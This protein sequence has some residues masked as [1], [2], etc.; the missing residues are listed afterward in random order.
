MKENEGLSLI[1]AALTLRSAG[2]PIT[3][4]SLDA[5][6]NAAGAQASREEIGAL[7]LLLEPEPR[8]E[9]QEE[10]ASQAA[11]P[12]ESRED[13]GP[14]DRALYVYAVAAGEPVAFAAAGID[15][16]PL[17]AVDTGGLVAVVHECSA[18]P[19]ASQE[20]EVV[21]GWVQEHNAVVAEALQHYDA[22]L[23]MA[24]DTLVFGKDAIEAT[25]R[26][27]QWLR[28]D[29]DMLRRKLDRI[30][31]RQEYG[32][33]VTWDLKSASRDVV[34]TCPAI[35]EFKKDLAGKPEGAAYFL[36]QQLEKQ[37]KKE[38]EKKA[39]AIFREVFDLAREHAVEVS[40]DKLK[41]AEGNVRMVANL[42]CLVE[43]GRDEALKAAFNDYCT[44]DGLA[45][46]V[47]GPWPAYSFV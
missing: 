26:V 8:A 2:R 11:A 13:P 18:Q 16:A 5:V 31:D 28:D 39:Q 19:Y 36:K 32:V 20:K 30:R 43:R 6:L 12:P 34:D 23:P 17:L 41:R 37:V 22:V 40:V 7:L 38:I 29:G 4:G 27:R 3:R 9:P 14:D 24:F 25:D 45:A 44:G 15:S 35:A 10:P 47:T 42:T 33:Q 1:H 21:E 46:R